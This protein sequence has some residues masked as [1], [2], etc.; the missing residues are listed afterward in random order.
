MKNKRLEFV[1][2]K[3]ELEYMYE[4]FFESQITVNKVIMKKSFMRNKINLAKKSYVIKDESLYEEN[5]DSIFEFSDLISIFSESKKIVLEFID[6]KKLIIPFRSFDS[7]D[8]AEEFAEFLSKIAD[9]NR[10]YEKENP[11]SYK[12]TDEIYL[13]NNLHKS[14]YGIIKACNSIEDKIANRNYNIKVFITLFIGLCLLTAVQV[15]CNIKSFELQVNLT[16]NII[17]CIIVISVVTILLISII[18]RK[19]IFIFKMN[20][21]NKECKSQY[22]K[23]SV[24]FTQD[25]IIVKLANQVEVYRL[26]DVVCFVKSKKASYAGSLY[27]R[28][29][30]NKL[31][32]VLIY[33]MI[34]GA[35]YIKI[36]IL[37]RISKPIE[38]N[39]NET[40]VNEVINSR[41]KYRKRMIISIFIII[42]ILN[43]LIS[44]S[45]SF[46]SV[47]MPQTYNKIETIRANTIAQSFKDAEIHFHDEIK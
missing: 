37:E 45:V 23:Y 24:T 29:N 11:R 41:N 9:R 32:K 36:G 40:V 25:E 26:D 5:I 8:N 28:I 16:G 46:T 39:K 30:E 35:E 43:K 6:G 19:K 13:E 27:I 21:L 15:Y 10:E 20:R 18:F 3:E 12:E 4:K 2:T 38:R 42:L 14:T 44:F 34:G 33:T 47:F 7:N 31:K 17:R 1:L 22:F